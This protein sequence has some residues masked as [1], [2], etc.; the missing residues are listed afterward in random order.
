MNALV[1]YRIPFGRQCQPGSH[2][3]YLNA[4]L[5]GQKNQGLNERTTAGPRG[6]PLAPTVRT[7]SDFFGP[8]NLSARGI[9]HSRPAWLNLNRFHWLQLF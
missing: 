6:S 2:H 4:R 7:L 3:F 1:T 8:N 9:F 5:L